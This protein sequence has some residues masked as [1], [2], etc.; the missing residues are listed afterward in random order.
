MLSWMN[1]LSKVIFILL[2]IGDD[3][4]VTYLCVY[5]FKGDWL[6]NRQTIQ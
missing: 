5:F 4:S 6:E 3:W 1:R 2:C